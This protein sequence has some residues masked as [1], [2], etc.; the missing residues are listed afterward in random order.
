MGGICEIEKERKAASN[1][2]RKRG[3]GLYIEGNPN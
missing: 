3:G 1:T 2:E